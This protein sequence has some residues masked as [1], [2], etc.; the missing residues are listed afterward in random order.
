MPVAWI[1]QYRP[2]LCL[3]WAQILI[4]PMYHD[5]IIIYILIIILF[6]LLLVL[7]LLSFSD[8]YNNVGA[9]QYLPPDFAEQ[10]SRI[11]KSPFTD[12]P[13][14]Y[15]NS[16]EIP[17]DYGQPNVRGTI[18]Q[19]YGVPTVRAIPQEHTV[20]DKT[21]E[22][23]AATTRFSD[24]YS[25]VITDVPQA[26]GAPTSRDSSSVYNAP[27]MRSIT[28]YGAPDLRTS[29]EQYAAP[30]PN[31]NNRRTSAVW[32]Y[33]LP[34]ARNRPQTATEG[35]RP[36]STDGVISY[37][38]KTLSNFHG[39]SN[40]PDQTYDAPISARRN[41]N[42]A[43]VNGNSYPHDGYSVSGSY[44]NSGKRISKQYGTPKERNSDFQSNGFLTS[45]R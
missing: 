9:R 23:T 37:D 38:Q 19:E 24:D 14:R 22:Y 7:F 1:P 45:G 16:N 6:Y 27:N 30:Q 35:S 17:R 8:G 39:A 21:S 41:Q 44:E 36:K 40:T 11:L 15:P 31:S 5:I 42:E 2:I 43:D 34:I 13:Y 12:Q 32:K 28:Q 29:S 4:S 10:S 33:G 25:G 26:Y 20:P 3:V 18:T